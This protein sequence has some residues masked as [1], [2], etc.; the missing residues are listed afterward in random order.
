VLIADVN[1]PM[2]V[3][4]RTDSHGWSKPVAITGESG[5]LGFNGIDTE[6]WDIF[7]ICFV[8][9]FFFFFLDTHSDHGSTPP[10]QPTKKTRARVQTKV[11]LP[12]EEGGP[13][14]TLVLTNPDARSAA[15]FRRLQ[16]AAEYWIVN[17]SGFS[18]YVADAEV[19][20]DEADEKAVVVRDS[21]GL[22]ETGHDA[23]VFGTCF[24]F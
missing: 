8:S 7:F 23:C 15:P 4:M 1:T 12:G 13:P 5:A 2:S 11:V 17:R 19:H 14:L 9:S 21:G 24:F 16:V 3:S 18:V 10:S 22:L 20:A 6:V